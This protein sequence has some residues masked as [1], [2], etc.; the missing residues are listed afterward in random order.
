MVWKGV[1]IVV[2]IVILFSSCF[3]IFGRRFVNGRRVGGRRSEMRFFSWNRLGFFFFEFRISAG[4]F[5]FN[6]NIGRF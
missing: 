5:G 3:W 2:S 1:C 6:F 4:G